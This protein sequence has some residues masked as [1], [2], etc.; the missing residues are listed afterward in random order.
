MQAE[1]VDVRA[2]EATPSAL[3]MTIPSFGNSLWQLD[4]FVI[5][6]ETSEREGCVLIQNNQNKQQAGHIANTPPN[7]MKRQ[8]KVAWKSCFEDG[9]ASRTGDRGGK[10]RRAGL[11]L[12]L[13][14][15]A[16]LLFG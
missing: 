10:L 7:L 15:D 5:S 14:Q 9:S 16:L 13:L 12:H 4:R 11:V 2:W 3:V 8:T 6:S 1:S